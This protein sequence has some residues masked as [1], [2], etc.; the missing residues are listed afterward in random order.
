MDFSSLIYRGGTIW[1]IEIGIYTKIVIN[2]IYD[3]NFDE[4]LKIE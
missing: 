2:C 3:G 1:N 4:F